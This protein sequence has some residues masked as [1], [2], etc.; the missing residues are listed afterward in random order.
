MDKLKHILVNVTPTKDCEIIIERVI[1]LAEKLGAYL[2]IV[3]VIHDPFAYSGWNLPMPSLHGDYERLVRE[4]TDRLRAIV[5]EQKIRSFPVE[6]LIVEGDPVEQ[7]VKLVQEKEIDLL[8]MPSHRE[9]R[10]EHFLF[11]KVNERLIRRMPCSILLMK[12]EPLIAC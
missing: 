1:A 11:G 6:L 2:H 10:I 8:V 5:K 3:D 4:T 9:D 7:I 12:Q